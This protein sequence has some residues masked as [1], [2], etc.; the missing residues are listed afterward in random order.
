MQVNSPRELWRLRLQGRHCDDVHSQSNKS[1]RLTS[2]FNPN[3]EELEMLLEAYFAQIE[4]TVNFLKM[5]EYIDDTKDY[6]NI[7]LEDKQN[8]IL[9]MGVLLSTTNLL[10]NACILVVGLFG[11]KFISNFLII[12]LEKPRLITL[13]QSLCKL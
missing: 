8:Q 2:N 3:V 5:K 11:I 7:M 9:Q 12:L 1:G 13:L 6:I 4:G 10:L